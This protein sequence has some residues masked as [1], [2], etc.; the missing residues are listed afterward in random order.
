[1]VHSI[2]LHAQLKPA[3]G[4]VIKVR[5][6]TRAVAPS[7]APLSMESL[8]SLP[9]KLI[10]LPILTYPGAHIAARE[11]RTERGLETS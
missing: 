11:L 6:R 3:N 1:M 10:R 4:N 8:I 5:R 7:P 9:T 2:R